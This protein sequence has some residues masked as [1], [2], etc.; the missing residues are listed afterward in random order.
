MGH[1]M[2]PQQFVAGGAE[3]HLMKSCNR[4]MDSSHSRARHLGCAMLLLLES[5][6]IGRFKLRL[7]LA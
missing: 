7:R 1:A 2:S 3:G 6:C 4:E 5:C